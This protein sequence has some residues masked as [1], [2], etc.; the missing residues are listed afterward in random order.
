MSPPSGTAS[1]FGAQKSSAGK[2]Q[3]RPSSRKTGL[4]HSAGQGPLA[5]AC[6]NR[7]PGRRPLRPRRQPRHVVVTHRQDG[8]PGPASKA[9]STFRVQS[10]P[11]VY[12]PPLE[13]ARELQALGHGLWVLS[14]RGWRPARRRVPPR[15]PEAH[16][17]FSSPALR[18]LAEMAPPRH[19]GPPDQQGG[20]SPRGRQLRPHMPGEDRPPGPPSGV[21]T[22]HR[23][24]LLF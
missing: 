9:G 8:A 7:Q 1:V 4:P 21:P 11:T 19:R 22:C 15:L 10:L 23:P 16:C 20:A 14:G 17:H 18:I 13:L 24:R 5:P 3:D 6:R 12:L 2:Q